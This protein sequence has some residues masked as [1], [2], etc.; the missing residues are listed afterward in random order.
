MNRLDDLKVLFNS[1]FNRGEPKGREMRRIFQWRRYLEW[2]DLAP[3]EKL[4]AKRFLFLPLLADIVIGIVNQYF[5]LIVLYL[6]LA[7]SAVSHHHL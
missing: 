7:Y 2:K 6:Y 4:S 5:S 1:L 3:E